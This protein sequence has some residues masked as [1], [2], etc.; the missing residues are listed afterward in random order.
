MFSESAD[1]YDLIYS[2]FKDFQEEARQVAALIK[3]RCPDARSILDVGCG[4][5]RHAATLNQEFAFQVDGLDIEPG[6]LQIAA[7]RCPEGTFTLGDMADFDLQ[8]RYDVV[9]CLFSSIGYVKTLERLRSAARAFRRHLL[10]GGVGLVEPWFAPDEFQ[11]GRV[12]LQTVDREDI[13]IARMSQ[14]QVEGHISRLEFHYL[15][16]G[17]DGVRHLEEVHELGLFTVEDLQAD[18]P[19]VL[20][21]SGHVE[22]RH[23]AGDRFAQ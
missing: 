18:D 22:L 23:R 4:T 12:Y 9:L 2:E 5:G 14:S 8:K 11:A 20:A 6:F 15:V 13:K 3:D 7:A 10:P 16:G 19:I 17:S 1:L 21:V